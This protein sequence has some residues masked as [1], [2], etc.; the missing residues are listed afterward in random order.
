VGGGA[1]ADDSG[2]GRAGDAPVPPMRTLGSA[3]R[4]NAV[5]GPQTS[6]HPP[7]EPAEK[8]A[9]ELPWMDAPG[10]GQSRMAPPRR[11][12]PV[13]SEGTAAGPAGGLGGSGRGM[14]GLGT[15]GTGA[16][17]VPAGPTSAGEVP[18]GPT[19]EEG[20][21]TGRPADPGPSM[22]AAGLVRRRPKSQSP[23]PDLDGPPAGLAGPPADGSSDD[24]EDPRP[25]YSWNP[26]DPTEAF[27]AVP[28]PGDSRPG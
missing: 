16:D 22:T 25:M 11:V 15:G 21:G 6:G 10:S 14:G 2:L 1:D 13:G 23:F 26:S 20:P 9:S 5:R 19:G 18:A 28:P 12:F 4:L 3:H 7:W 17:E 8:P 27:P 24:A